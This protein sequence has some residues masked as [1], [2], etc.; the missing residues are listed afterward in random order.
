MATDRNPLLPAVVRFLQPIASFSPCLSS[1]YSLTLA[2]RLLAPGS[3]YTFY[4]ISFP[5]QPC[6]KSRYLFL[7]LIGEENGTFLPSKWQNLNSDSL[8]SDFKA[9]AL[10]TPPR[11]VSP[12]EVFN[13]TPPIDTM[14]TVN[15]TMSLVGF[16]QSGLTQIC[17][18]SFFPG[19]THPPIPSFGPSTTH[20]FSPAS[21]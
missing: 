14:N 18:S 10:W 11:I 5:W 17:Y 16:Q 21:H 19:L 15:T 12:Y 6:V 13:S 9:P 2:E 1:P 7:H 8:L 3:I 4:I 20:L